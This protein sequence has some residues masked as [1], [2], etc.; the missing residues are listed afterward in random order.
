[1]PAFPPFI[2]PSYQLNSINMDAQRSVNLFPVKSEVETS[3]SIAALEGT[4]GIETFIELPTFPGRGGIE[5]NGRA[6][7]VFGNTLYEV[8]IDGTYVA[9]GTL[10]TSTGP[11]SISANG[12]QICIVDN[13]DGY[14]FNINTDVFTQITDPYYLGAVTVD[15]IDG[16]FVF[17]KPDSQIYF[18]SA[19]YNGLTGDPLDFAS[20]EGSPDDLVAVKTVHQQVWLFGGQTAQVVYNSGDADFPLSTVQGSLMQYGCT[21]PYS[22]CS[23][24]NTVFW[25]GN[26]QDGYGVV[27]MAT[28]YQPQRIS[29]HAVERAIQSYGTLSNAVGYTYQEDGHF[30]YVLN[31]NSANTTWVY[32][33]GLQQWHE[34]AYFDNGSYQRQ[35][36]QFHIFAFNKHLVGDYEN[37][38]LYEQALSI[39]TDD[40]APIRRMRIS[41]H[42]A[43]DLQY[44]YYSQFQL[45]MQT[46]IGLDGTTTQPNY[47]PQ[48]ALSWSNDGAHTWSNEYWV[49]AGK[50]GQYKT[51]AIWRRLGRAR[52]RV[53]KVVFTAACKTYWIAAHIR[54]E[55]GTN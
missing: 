35:R 53:F 9:R 1:M 26:D 15:F 39:Y 5:Q 30:F 23:S 18:I 46:G 2:G 7:C 28:G 55:S 13:P 3:K 29:T 32:D 49:S 10:N 33:V 51:R 45:D 27:F 34:R 11:V 40:G 37:G 54:T 25:L 42:I 43:D 4:P 17:N 50:I 36:Q 21:A 48:I 44:L 20:A 47:N 41:P 31:F 22:V 6:F 12:S 52:D 8:F 14:I 24:A 38:K 19:L 16:Y